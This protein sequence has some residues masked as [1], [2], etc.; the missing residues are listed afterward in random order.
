MMNNEGVA[1]KMASVQK[2]KLRPSFVPESH[3]RR[4]DIVNF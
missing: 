3:L 2:K 1:K 4:L